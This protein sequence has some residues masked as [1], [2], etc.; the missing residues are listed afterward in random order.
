LSPNFSWQFDSK[1]FKILENGG[2]EFR[3]AT[4]LIV[5]LQ[6]KVNGSAKLF[7]DAANIDD[8][9]NMAKVE[10]ARWTWCD[11]RL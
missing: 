11:A 5:I 2:F 3:P 9:E 6:S 1:P 8:V 10:V 7:C 4:P